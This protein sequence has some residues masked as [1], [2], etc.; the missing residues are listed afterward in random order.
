MISKNLDTENITITVIKVEQLEFYNVIIHPKDAG[1][2]AGVDSDQCCSFI[3]CWLVVLGLNSPLRQYS[4]YIG[5]SQREGERKE[6]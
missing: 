3:G 5:V 2:T 4:V 1:K 6:N